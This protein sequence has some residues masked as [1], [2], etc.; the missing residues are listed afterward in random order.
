MLGIW[1]RSTMSCLR[2]PCCGKAGKSLWRSLWRKTLLSTNFSVTANSFAYSEKLRTRT[3][4]SQ[5]SGTRFPDI[6]SVMYLLTQCHR[7]MYK[8]VL[9]LWTLVAD[10]RIEESFVTRDLNLIVEKLA[11]VRNFLSMHELSSSFLGQYVSDP[12]TAERKVGLSLALTWNVVHS[13]GSLSC[14]R[15]FG[16]QSVMICSLTS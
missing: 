4:S 15:T 10:E 8:S 3:F 14:S 7:S 16:H 9:T 11:S 12:Y 5:W 2:K 13:S 1:T 6:I